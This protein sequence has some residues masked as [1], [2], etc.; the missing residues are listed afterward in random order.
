[1]DAAVFFS[2]RKPATAPTKR[3]WILAWSK[4]CLP[5]RVRPR[6]RL[7]KREWILAWS[8]TFVGMALVWLVVPRL[9]ESSSPMAAAWLGMA[10]I[11]LALHFG[12]FQL[13]AL[14]WR[15]GGVAI[16]P[17]MNRPLAAT[18]LAD[19]WGRRW[20]RAFRILADDFV[21]C[22]LVRSLGARGALVAAFLFSGLVHDAVIS[23]PARGGYGL[24]TLYFLIQAA[25][26]LAVHSRVALRL[27][28]HHGP[29]AR[30]WA[31]VV[32]VAPLG[33]LFPPPFVEAV[34]LPFLRAVQPY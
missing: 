2:D 20:N 22:P 4:T 14:A 11:V 6:F 15:R 19:F 29:L 32:V 8:K 25:G 17:I 12:L 7:T 1:M 18:S 3:E 13:A 28:F 23:V 33:L 30:L 21:Y 16:E 31:W 34:V 27:G 10:G 24:P 5:G 9:F 26:L